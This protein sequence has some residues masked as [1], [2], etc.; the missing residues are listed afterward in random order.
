MKMGRRRRCSSV[1]YQLT[2]APSSRPAKAG[3]AAHFD[4][5]ESQVIYET[6]H[7]D[8]VRL[9]A[10]E[11]RWNHS[12]YLIIQVGGIFVVATEPSS[13]AGNGKRRFP[14]GAL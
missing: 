11:S 9:I 7:E 6:G 5:N 1:T 8:D 2:Y 10:T 12:Q 14:P 4:R 3:P 13:S